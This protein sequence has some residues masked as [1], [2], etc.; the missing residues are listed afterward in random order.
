MRNLLLNVGLLLTT[1]VNLTVAQ[2]PFNMTFAVG[3][4]NALNSAGLSSLATAA[5]QAVSSTAGQDLVMSLGQGYK[6]LLAPDNNAIAKVAA[7]IAANPGILLPVLQYHVL[8][9]QFNTSNIAISPSHTIARSSLNDST[10]VN[11]EGGTPQAVVLTSDGSSA[12]VLNQGLQVNITNSV[13]AGTLTVLV[14][15][16]VLGIPGNITTVLDAT[17]LKAFQ[18]ANLIAPLA[19]AHGMTFFAPVDS[20]L[21]SAS[22][23]LTAAIWGNHIING[24]TV[25]STS[26]SQGQYAS[27]SGTRFTFTTNSS[28]TF[29]TSGQATAKIIQ[30]DVLVQ[31][32]VV[33]MIDS[34]L[35]ND[36]TGNQKTVGIS[37]VI[38]T[39]TSSAMARGVAHTR[40]MLAIAAA[41]VTG[42]MAIL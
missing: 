38:S 37:G 6:T 21:T 28:G 25:Y 12:K 4:L 14:V 34:V 10:F 15:D 19:A 31:N 35:F 20:A 27:A 40:E 42:M 29:V 7:V 3:L 1:I 18:A 8:E 2:Q 32:G 23:T 5:G 36:Q 39:G 17:Q 24:S 9:G 26:L 30:S 33:H 22:N 13:V 41:S 16:S 11:L